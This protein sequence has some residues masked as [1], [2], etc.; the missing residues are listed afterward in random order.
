M[1]RRHQPRLEEARVFRSIPRSAPHRLPSAAA[2]AAAASATAATRRVHRVRARTRA[3]RRLQH[4]VQAVGGVALRAR[5][6]APREVLIRLA[7]GL[8]GRN[9]LGLRATANRVHCA[10]ARRRRRRRL[11]RLR[12][13][14]RLLRRG[15]VGTV[16][17]YAAVGVDEASASQEGRP[18]R[19]RVGRVRR[20][21]EHLCGKQS[22]SDLGQLALRRPLSAPGRAPGCPEPASASLGQSAAWAALAGHTGPAFHVKAHRERA[23]ARPGALSAQPRRKRHMAAHVR[24]V[25]RVVAAAVLRVVEQP[26]LVPQPAAEGEVPAPAR[27]VQRRVPLSLHRVEVNPVLTQPPRCWQQLHALRPGALAGRRAQPVLRAAGEDVELLRVHAALFHQVPRDLEP[28]KPPVSRASRGRRRPPRTGAAPPPAGRCAQQS[29]VAG[30]ACCASKPCP[31]R[32][33]LARQRSATRVSEAGRC[34][35]PSEPRCGRS[36]RAGAEPRAAADAARRGPRQQPNRT[37][38]QASSALVLARRAD[39]DLR[40]AQ[41]SISSGRRRTYL[42]NCTTT[43]RS[44]SAHML[45]TVFSHISHRQTRRSEMFCA[46]PWLPPLYPSRIPSHE[47]LPARASHCHACQT[48]LIVQGRALLG[49]HE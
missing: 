12:R 8:E 38:R 15:M 33:P 18:Y 24:H 3:A 23:S 31:R 13:R 41:G 11:R 40:I 2:T 21:A 35:P 26:A 45:H 37:R 39:G 44:Y 16:G 5:T 1:H 29:V 20:Q 43:S 48:A 49:Q 25:C 34:R 7:H 46:L 27:L 32:Q 30:A 17:W 14:R 10:R 22:G 36:C 4:G 9:G 6:S 47:H 19:A 42:S 28:A